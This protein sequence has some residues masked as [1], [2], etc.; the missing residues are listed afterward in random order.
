MQV[1]LL[2]RVPN[3]GQ[4]GDVVKVKPGYARNFLLPKHKA[5]RASEA[6]KKLFEARRKEIEA[7]D[8]ERRKEAEKVAETMAGTRIVLV[9]QAGESGQLYGS[10]SAR[11]IADSL[12]AL[13]FSVDRGQ[14]ELARPVK[15]LGIGTVVVRL[16]PEVTVDIRLNVARSEAEAELQWQTG[17]AIVGER[18]EEPEV[19]AAEE[20]AEIDTEQLVADLLEESQRADTRE[21]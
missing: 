4:T 14:I 21:A 6:N 15:E 8:L 3:L 17:G 10:A 2:E 11:D 16:H 1:I 12:G 7:R 9:R 5:L 13:G 20:E 19:E 18:D